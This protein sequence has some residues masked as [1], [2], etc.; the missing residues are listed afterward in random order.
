MKAK[1]KGNITRILP[2]FYMPGTPDDPND[3][4]IEADSIE[5]VE[6]KPMRELKD[7]D[8]LLAKDGHLVFVEDGGLAKLTW[9]K[10]SDCPTEYPDAPILFNLL[11]LVAE[12]QKVRGGASESIG[13]IKAYTCNIGLHEIIRFA[14]MKFKK[15]D[16]FRF[17]AQLLMLA[18]K[19]I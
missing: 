1:I 17:A 8:M 10:K 6:E 13:D 4:T 18:R 16:A 19:D 3:I 9:I 12:M 2:K 14:G 15:S 11:D 7:G 5:I